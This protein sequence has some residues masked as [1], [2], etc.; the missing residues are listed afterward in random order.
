MN[1]Y[2]DF[3]NTKSVAAAFM[4]FDIEL[5]DI[6]P[7]LLGHQ[8]KI[9]QWCIAGGRRAIF[10]A[11]GLGKSVMQLEI[12]R[13]IIVHEGARCL[14]VCPLG[15]R[16]EFARDARDL[17]CEQRQLPAAPARLVTGRDLSEQ[18]RERTRVI[19]DD[20]DEKLEIIQ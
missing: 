10:A 19:G 8:R 17:G 1:D 13:Q 6:H 2:L 15:V 11:F 12:M 16:Q 4:G 3:L 18:D 9:V 5:D 14:I 20:E 7:V